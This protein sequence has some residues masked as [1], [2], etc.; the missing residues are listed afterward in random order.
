M[1]E[2]CGAVAAVS[3]SASGEDAVGDIGTAA[4]NGAAAGGGA[5]GV[6]G[7]GGGG[8]LTDV[9]PVNGFLYSLCGFSTSM[10]LGL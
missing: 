1:G 2:P 9:S 10:V 3:R 8:A 5:T 4:S 6:G 7:V